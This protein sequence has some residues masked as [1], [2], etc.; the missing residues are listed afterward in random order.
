MRRPILAVDFDGT[1]VEHR[2]PDIGPPIEGALPCLR[3]LKREGVMLILWTCRQG[4]R[5]REAVEWCKAQGIE[6]DAVNED[7]A[8]TLQAFAGKYD[9]TNYKI[10]GDRYIDD[11]NIGEPVD[12]RKWIEVLREMRQV[13]KELAA[14][15]G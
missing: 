6:F 14:E 15:V 5:L 8:Q 13:A 11:R 12:K 4:E 10:Y 1:I 3:L 2:Y 9:G 7:C